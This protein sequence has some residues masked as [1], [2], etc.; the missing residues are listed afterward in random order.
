MIEI[1]EVGVYALLEAVSIVVCL[2]YLFGEKLHFD[3]ITICYLTV[4]VIL[5]EAL[6]LFDIGSG[7]SLIVFPVIFLY[8]GLKFGFKVK[9][10]IINNFLWVLI[11]TIL[12]TTI[13]MLYSI[14]VHDNKLGE[15]DGII[16]NTILLLIV[17][18]GLRRCKLDRLSY[19]LQYNEKIIWL[20]LTVA[21]IAIIIFMLNYKWN[22]RIEILY[23]IVLG[24]CILLIVI[25]A[26]DIGK[27]KIKVKET[28]AELR[29]HKLYESS[30]RD[31]IDD[32]CA[33]QHEFDNH[34]NTIYSQHHLYKT[35][36]ELVEVQKQYCEAIL[37]DNHYNKLLSKGNP[38]ILC[39]LYSQFL[40]IEKE[41]IEVLYQV[42][43]GDMECGMPVHKMVEL[44]RNL[45]KNAV[46]AIQIRRKGK[47]KVSITEENARIQ[48]EIANESEFIEEKKIRDFFKK[49]YSEKGSNRGYGLYNVGKIC[50]EYRA[51]LLC[52]NEEREGN[53]WLIFR[54]IIDKPL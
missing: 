51:A 30:F 34:I 41:N 1:V 19:S 33:K 42:N 23:Y 25:A 5:M 15:L 31:L 8:S 29:L 26:I 9:P 35:Y 18:T 6:Y 11:L 28:E 3:R 52:K 13:M 20:S 4:D 36:D 12:Q 39:F 53:N 49:G 10:L 46:E 2:H 44:L 40:E 38:V 45:I 37:N 43:I 17:M 32:I 16:V 7:W 22:R 21:V 50:E 54:V 27:N 24:T 14:V 48:I 47:L